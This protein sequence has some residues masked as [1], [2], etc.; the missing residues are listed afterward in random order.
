MNSLRTTYKAANLEFSAKLYFQTTKR[1]PRKKLTLC[2]NNGSKLADEL[3][4]ALAQQHHTHSHGIEITY[5]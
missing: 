1:R 5:V 3:D 4:M 2:T